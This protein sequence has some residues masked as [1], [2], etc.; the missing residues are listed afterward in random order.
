M[1]FYQ[2]IC[3]LALIINTVLEET[4]ISALESS[5][6]FQMMLKGRFFKSPWGAV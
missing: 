6:G 2:Y 1:T 4:P 5:C 3:Y